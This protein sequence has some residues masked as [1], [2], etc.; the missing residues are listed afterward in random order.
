MPINNYKLYKIRLLFRNFILT[1]DLEGLT[2]YKRYSE[3]IRNYF[4]ISKLVFSHPI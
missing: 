3:Q 4:E 2:S 1:A